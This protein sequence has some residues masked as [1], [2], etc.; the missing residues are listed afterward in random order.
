MGVTPVKIARGLKAITSDLRRCVRTEVR[1]WRAIPRSALLFLTYRCTSRCATCSIWRKGAN[2][3]GEL[4]LQQWMWV[5]DVLAENGVHGVELFGGDVFLRKDV[6]FPLARYMK[7]LGM[8]IHLPTNANL[9]DRPTAEEVVASGIDFLYISVDGVSRTHD[10]IRG[11]D[12]T[13]GRTVRAIE[14]VVAARGERSGPKLIC[15][16]TVSKFNA[17]SLEDILR[18]AKDSGFD[19]IHFEYVG[20]MTQEQIDNSIVNGLRPEPYYVRHGE[21]VLLDREGARGLKKTLRRIRLLHSRDGIG[22]TTV[23]IDVLSQ[24]DL[25]E[26]TIPSVKCYQERNEVT[27]DPYGNIVACPFINNY[28]LGNVLRE[29]FRQIWNNAKHRTLRRLQNAG[30][31]EIC[32]H[33][34]LSAQRNPCF[35]TRLK[36]IYLGRIRNNLINLP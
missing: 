19:E 23:N 11:I 29:D 16:T 36:R 1:F 17:R 26:G 10:R 30:K 24:R 22:I 32:R 2:G 14:S 27:M 21:S 3:K 20:E 7:R 28:V 35:A 33:C 18:F 25:Y 6:L 5:A 9:L 12:G 13:F 8:C 15:N 34:I 4:S 31:V